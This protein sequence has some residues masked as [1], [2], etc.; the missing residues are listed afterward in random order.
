MSGRAGRAATWW[1]VFRL[2]VAP[3]VAVGILVIEPFL[4]RGKEVESFESL[5]PTELDIAVSALRGCTETSTSRLSDLSDVVLG[6]ISVNEVLTSG[7]AS[8][9]RRPRALPARSGDESICSGDSRKKN[10]DWWLNTGCPIVGNSGTFTCFDGVVAVSRV[11]LTI[12]GTCWA[13]C[14]VGGL[15]AYCGGMTSCCGKTCNRW[16][17]ANVVTEL[18]SMLGIMHPEVALTRPDVRL[19]DVGRRPGA[20]YEG[21]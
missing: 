20:K 21:R 10:R 7:L 18:G 17:T 13:S 16:G 19:G 8:P 6:T 14:D 4:F 11:E 9:P 15:G 5:D 2:A 12:P 3:V 1:P